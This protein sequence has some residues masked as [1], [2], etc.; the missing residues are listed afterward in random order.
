MSLAIEALTQAF[1]AQRPHG[2]TLRGFV[3]HNTLPSTSTDEI[4][5]LQ[6]SIQPLPRQ[7][8]QEQAYLVGI[9]SV[10]DGRWTTHCEGT[11]VIES[12]PAHNGLTTQASG[13]NPN[14]LAEKCSRTATLDRI[15]REDSDPYQLHPLTIYGC[16]QHA[17]ASA[18][19]GE[20]HGGGA[21][22]A[23]VEE[24]KLWRSGERTCEGNWTAHAADRDVL[25]EGQVACVD[26][27]LGDEGG[28]L[29]STLR[30]LQVVR[31]EG[32][33]REAFDADIPPREKNAL[34]PAF[35]RPLLG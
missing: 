16:L 29:A 23:E 22:V 4:L 17:L 34:V 3:F 11:A 10:Y 18:A 30:G 6:T 24:F 13:S 1:E 15:A 19:P 12:K 8:G 33:P 35:L 14:K 31:C 32:E 5:E 26:V 21:K 25:L 20:Q 27:D 2:F 9:E 28:V 7:A